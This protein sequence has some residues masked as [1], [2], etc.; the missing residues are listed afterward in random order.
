MGLFDGCLLISDIDGTLLCDGKIPENNLSAIEEFKN[1]GGLF[2][3]ATGRSASA[4][5]ESYFAA[6]CNAPAIV[7]QGGGVFDFESDAFIS[8]RVLS[9]EDKQIALKVIQNN[10]NVGVEVHAG[11]DLFVVRE[12]AG[13]IFHVTYE[14]M[15]F[16]R[17]E[18]KDIYDIPWNKLLFTADSLEDFEGLCDYFYSLN[19]KKCSFMH[20]MTYDITRAVELYPLDVHKGHAVKF[21]AEKYKKTPYCIGDYY[22]DLELIGVSPC[23]AATKEAPNEVKQIAGYI[24]CGVREGAVADYIGFIKTLLRGS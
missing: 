2:T 18:I 1:E 22:N 19:Y 6:G 7:L 17:A 3:I 5:K 11:K 10:K 21:L 12:N 4:A 15:P 24:T 9:D 13:L 23:G 14:K 8:Q 20:T 16:K